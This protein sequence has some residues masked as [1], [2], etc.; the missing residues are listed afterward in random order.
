MDL[1]KV[2][3]FVCED[4]D[5]YNDYEDFDLMIRNYR[6]KLANQ[7]DVTSDLLKNAK[8]LGL[9]NDEQILEIQEVEEPCDRMYYFLGILDTQTK[10]TYGKLMILLISIG[11][12]FIAA[13]ISRNNVIERYFEYKKIN[14]IE[15]TEEEK[16]IDGKIL[17]NFVDIR[18]CDIFNENIAHTIYFPISEQ[19]KQFSNK[20]KITS[21]FLEYLYTCLVINRKQIKEIQN[22]KKQNVEVIKLMTS[23][24][25]ILK[26]FVIALYATGQ[27][28]LAQLLDT[29]C[30]LCKYI[31]TFNLDKD[32]FI[33]LIHHDPKDRNKHFREYYV[34]IFNK[35]ILN[36][37]FYILCEEL[38]VMTDVN[39]IRRMK[40]NDLQI[41][42]ILE[43]FM[44]T[45]HGFP[46][47]L[48]I[49]K[50]SKN[51]ELLKYLKTYGICEYNVSMKMNKFKELLSKQLK[52]DTYAKRVKKMVSSGLV[53]GVENIGKIIEQFRI[54]YNVT[55]SR[56]LYVFE[57]LPLEDFK[58][59]YQPL[60]DG[61]FNPVYLWSILVK[62]PNQ[63]IA[64][65]AIFLACYIAKNTDIE[66]LD[67]WNIKSQV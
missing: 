14:N 63:N 30:E 55:I 4:N 11:R 41:I 24:N 21:D 1:L 65:A 56:W 19:F 39:I 31:T 10:Y 54:N 27:F 52:R 53:S 32:F 40:R 33:K 17:P 20:V 48:I 42:A 45:S 47:F 64:T 8:L 2:H 16:E 60:I 46:K 58:K 35:L 12:V 15:L 50:Y 3:K 37:E 62:Y 61:T 38:H 29:K 28:W 67:T 5:E 25:G 59:I 51:D 7:I 44:I 18:W 22:V 23:T 9:I 13:Q 6:V 26:G 57:I 43:K 36:D 34:S 49:L 66:H